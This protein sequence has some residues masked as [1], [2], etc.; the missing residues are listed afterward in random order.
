M[1]KKIQVGKKKMKRRSKVKV[2]KEPKGCWKKKSIFFKLEYWEHLVLR[3]NLDVSHIENNICD[4]LLGT[5]LNIPGK[6]KDEIGTRL[7]LIEMGVR[8][9]LAPKVGEKRTY[10]P[11]AS[12]TLTKEEKRVMCQCLFDVKVPDGYSSNIRALVDMKE[13]KLVGLKSHDCHTL[14]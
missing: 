4:S 12:F 11:P 7:D 2:M 1:G 13:L 9:E 6:T 3:H 10:L 5:L 8:K 14:I